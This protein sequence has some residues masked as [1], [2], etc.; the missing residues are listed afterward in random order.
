MLVKKIARKTIAPK[1]R[2]IKGTFGKMHT[3]LKVP[4]IL[5]L[6]SEIKLEIGSGPV[7]GKNEWTTLDLCDQSDLWWELRDGLP[8]PDNSVSMI[9]SS[10]VLEHFCY[11]ELMRLLKDCLRVLEPGGVFSACVPD[12]SMY[13]MGYLNP[14]SFD[15]GHLGYKPAVISDQRMDIVNYVAYMDGH[16]KYMFDKESLVH[17]LSLAGFGS[18]HIR[19]F[20]ASLDLPKRRPGSIYVCCAKPVGAAEQLLGV[21]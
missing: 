18:V 12:A 17:V 21:P 20:D 7:R 14:D 19:E 4:R 13:I 16:H 3:R 15:R 5:K 11:R 1:F 2:Q 10:H 8:F 6:G 9:Y